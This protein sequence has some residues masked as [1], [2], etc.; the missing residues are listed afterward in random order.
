[1]H[2]RNNPGDV[3]SRIYWHGRPYIGECPAALTA[4][5]AGRDIFLILLYALDPR[6][7]TPP[8]RAL[9]TA[10]ASF[11]KEEICF[12]RVRFPPRYCN[13]TNNTPS[14]I[15]SPSCWHWYIDAHA[16][17][18]SL[19]AYGFETLAC[20]LTC[21]KSSHIKNMKI[22]FSCCIEF[23]FWEQKFLYLNLFYGNYN[24]TLK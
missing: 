11:A 10:C 6:G 1:M 14:E 12:L 22:I 18:V 8:V 19:A 24:Y 4:K 9:I 20:N 17:A 23:G 16:L 3:Y 5:E 13:T 21:M 2:A 15:R 7:P